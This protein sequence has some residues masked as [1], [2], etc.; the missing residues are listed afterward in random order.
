M[1]PK[2]IMF[3]FIFTNA[4]P[5]DCI[6]ALPLQQTYTTAAGGRIDIKTDFILPLPKIL[7]HRNIADNLDID[8]LIELV[9]SPTTV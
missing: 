8:I 7:Y 2:R 6:I 4:P 5:R 9:I 1:Q 3:Y